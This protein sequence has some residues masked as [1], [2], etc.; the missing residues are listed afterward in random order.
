[1]VNMNKI[2]MGV[3][4]R[5]IASEW[6]SKEEWRKT[7]VFMASN[8]TWTFNAWLARAQPIIMDDDHVDYWIISV[9]N[10]Q[11][12]ARWCGERA[13]GFL[14][15]TLLWLLL[16]I[17]QRSHALNLALMM[18]GLAALRGVDGIGFFDNFNMFTGSC[19]GKAFES[20]VLDEVESWRSFSS[21]QFKH[22]SLYQLVKVKGQPETIVSQL[23]FLLFSYM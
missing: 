18:S 22:F 19:L 11:W 16:S 20:F 9:E 7:L 12:A 17:C 1:M 6:E 5:A 14:L 2:N 4:K 3:K 10:A 23:V 8:Q 15:S 21:S 13:G